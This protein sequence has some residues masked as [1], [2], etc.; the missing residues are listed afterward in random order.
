MR[1]KAYAKINLGLDILHKRVDGYHE[2]AMLMQSIA[3]ADEVE[4][5]ESDKLIVE[6]DVSTIPG[7]PNN[8][9]WKAALCLAQKSGRLPNV[10]VFI[11]KRIFAAAGLAGGSTDAAAVLRGLNK[12]WNLDLSYEELEILAAEIGSDVPFCIRGG[13]VLATG[14]GEILTPLPDLP[15][16]S[17]LLVKPR[18]DISTAWAYANYQNQRVIHHPQ[19]DV[20]VK[21]VLNEDLSTL[22]QNIGNVLES[23]AC[24]EYPVLKQLKQS[25]LDSGAEVA[26]M[27]GSGPTIFGI[28]RNQEQG[29][30]IESLL[31]KQYEVDTEVT[32]T[33]RRMVI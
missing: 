32:K 7:G 2:V 4:I 5:T 16:L 22:Y 3:L 17:L 24:Q 8:I 18:F 30:Y 1:E 20:L 23:V 19:I 10:R 15:L 13:T 11:R 28:M 29:Q 27:S 14:R 33:M 26:L 6:T 25:L 21:A 9:A 31:K 12:F